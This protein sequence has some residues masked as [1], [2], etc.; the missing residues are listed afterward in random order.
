M[1]ADTRGPGRND[2]TWITGTPGL[3]DI[4][5]DQTDVEWESIGLPLAD[6]SS[7]GEVD[8][9]RALRDAETLLGFNAHGGHVRARALIHA[10][11]S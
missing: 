8:C 2:I 11:L 10:V 3:G 7:P 5:V 6:I 1:I 9:S 4:I